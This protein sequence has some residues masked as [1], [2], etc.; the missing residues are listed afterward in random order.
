[1]N[2]D[3]FEDEDKVSG[4]WFLMIHESMHSGEQ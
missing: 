1:M 3:D 2:M 4:M